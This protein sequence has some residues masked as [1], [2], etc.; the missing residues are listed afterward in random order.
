[1]PLFAWPLTQPAPGASLGHERKRAAIG[2]CSGRKSLAE[3]RP[4]MV[5]LARTLRHTR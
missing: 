4:E 3:T 1:M 2:K 5:E